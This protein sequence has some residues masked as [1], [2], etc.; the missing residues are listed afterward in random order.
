VNWNR[1]IADILLQGVW[2]DSTRTPSAVQDEQR[3]VAQSARTAT[4]VSEG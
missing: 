1:I 2:V 3:F 4:M